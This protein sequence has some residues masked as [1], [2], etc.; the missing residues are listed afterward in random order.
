MKK[1][2]YLIALTQL[3]S[4][5][6]YEATPFTGQ[7]LPRR[8]GYVNGITNDWIYYNLRTGKIYNGSSVDSD[9][10]EG[11]QYNRTD[12]DLAFCGNKLRTNSGASGIGKGGAADLGFQ[13]Y[14]KWTSTAQ[15]PADLQ[16]VVD[17]DS[18][19]I[20]M[21]QREWVSQQAKT[22]VV[23]IPW[24][25]PNKGPQQTYTKANP[26]LNEA[27]HFSGPPPSYVP[28]FHTYLIRTADG[29]H[30]FKLQIV[31]WYDEHIEIG[32]TGG[33]ISFYV[34]EVK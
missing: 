30:Y 4:C 14:E 7:I 18:V 31:S 26:L 11:K 20:T 9:I 12:W 25:D 10:T 8:S 33:K 6:K 1:I 21:A 19:S 16:W 22:G 15:L 3:F 34:E 32:D 28:S 2:V 5:V 17:R 29:A 27:L 23:E 24:F 13:G